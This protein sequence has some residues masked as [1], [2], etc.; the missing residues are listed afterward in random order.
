M[1][2][3]K[4]ILYRCTNEPTGIKIAVHRLFAFYFKDT[5]LVCIMYTEVTDSTHTMM[6]PRHNIPFT[7]QLTSLTLFYTRGLGIVVLYVMV[8]QPYGFS[9]DFLH[10]Y[11]KLTILKFSSKWVKVMLPYR[12]GRAA[13]S[14]G[15]GEV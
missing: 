8:S 1:K 14:G 15:W 12:G 5:L 10:R 13:C 2:N 6:D 7:Y 4:V 9:L 3:E 11:G